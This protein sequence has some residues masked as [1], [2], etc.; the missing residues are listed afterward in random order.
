MSSTSSAA[1]QLSRLLR[2]RLNATAIAMIG[3]GVL[4]ALLIWRSRDYYGG[5]DCYM[6][7]QIVRHSWEHPI[8]LLNHWG[9]P[10]FVL[11]ASPFARF[12]IVGISVLNVITALVTAWLAMD[13]TGRLGFQRSALAVVLVFSC[14]EFLVGSISP[15]I[16]ILFALLLVWSIW[17]FCRDRMILSA[18]V[19]SFLPLVRT[20]GYILLPLFAVAL[21]WRRRLLLIPCL[22]GGGLLYS[23]I[24]WFVYGDF[25]WL[26][27]RSPYSAAAAQVYGHGD[28]LHFVRHYRFIVGYP[29]AVLLLVGIGYLA[30]LTVAGR[31]MG[32]EPR[33][34][35]IFLVVGCASAYLA[36][37]SFVWWR[38]IGAS[39]GLLRVMA[40]ITPLLVVIAMAGA[41]WLGKILQTNPSFKTMVS[42]AMALLALVQ[43]FRQYRLPVPL[44][45]ES[46]VMANAV[47]WLQ[48]NGLHTRRLHYYNPYA[49]YLLEIDPFDGRCGRM[50][51][52]QD[53][54]PAG[55]M[56]SGEVL[57][58]DAHFGANEGGVKLAALETD[59][60]MTAL[61]VFRPAHPFRTLNGYE[62]EVWVFQRL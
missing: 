56:Q 30:Y 61:K 1:R 25:L 15:V 36:A 10:L 47:A 22:A 60:R 43:P 53:A 32:K 12:G 26:V 17:L 34:P 7:Y 9:K 11:L 8:L 62:Y 35:A 59:A 42:S 44:T 38:G 5:A 37:H 18:L 23:T 14:P 27:S 20:E 33:T 49:A 16:E 41:T 19:I 28:L 52:A 31:L 4:L 29:V 45:A 58:W 3:L 40:G 54:P 13:L 46:Q 50:V 39:L 48:Q 21:A 2:A 55:G 24:G 51:R 57:I 6:R